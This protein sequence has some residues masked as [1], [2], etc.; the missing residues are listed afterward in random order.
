M[1]FRAFLCHTFFFSVLFFSLNFFDTGSIHGLFRKEYLAGRYFSRI[2]YPLS[3]V[4]A[5]FF[6]FAFCVVLVK[7]RLTLSES[8]VFIFFHLFYFYTCKV[9]AFHS[10]VENRAFA[11]ILLFWLKNC[12]YF[13]AIHKQCGDRN[14]LLSL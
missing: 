3:V 4:T 8:S 9:D 14:L 2:C 11:G 12:I 6:Q 5:D 1:E 10:S 7:N 13:L